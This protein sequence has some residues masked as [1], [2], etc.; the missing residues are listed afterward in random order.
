MPVMS[1]T[2]LQDQVALVTGAGSGLGAA[3]AHRLADEGAHVVVND[4][5]P[6]AAEV[7]AKELDGEVAAFDVAD[8][9]A[10]DAAV[11][12]LVARHGRIDVLINNA[13]IVTDRPEVFE[14]L[15][16]AQ[17][18][19]LS[20]EPVEP[21]RCFST[22]TDEQFDRMMRTHVYGT[23]NG[24]RAALRHMEPARAGAI[25]N[26]C[27]V[28]S[29]GGSVAT[30][31]YAAAKHAIAGLTKSV[32]AEVAPL[33]IR[34][35]AVAPG[36][37]DTPLLDPLADAKPFLVARIPA[38]RLGQATEVAELVRYL[39]CDAT[40]SFGEILPVSGGWLA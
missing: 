23:F 20:G 5:R 21:V 38:G 31:E 16:A 1:D 18:A 27:S 39:V 32:G 24:M 14:R 11:D 2:V 9:A 7:V 12:G 26:L 17:M 15:M 33:G 3:I 35:N 22:L 36:F 37:I 28:Y 19:A 10:F 6:D 29:Y 8:S 34:I 13:G 40:Y 25:V 30:P 4:L